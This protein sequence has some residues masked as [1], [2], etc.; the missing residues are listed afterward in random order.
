MRI[1]G[2]KGCI[3]QRVD[4]A[5][6]TFDAPDELAER[7]IAAGYAERAGVGDPGKAIAEDETATREA[8]EVAATRTTRTTR[9]T[10]RRRG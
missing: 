6:E 10:R 4:R 8:P 1:K 3:I 9:K 7:L 5:G 2:R